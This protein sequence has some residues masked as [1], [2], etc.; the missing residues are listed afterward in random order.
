[1]RESNQ[2]FFVNDQKSLTSSSTYDLNQG[3]LSID[4]GIKPLPGCMKTKREDFSIC[5]DNIGHRIVACGGIEPFAHKMVNTIEVYDLK[6]RR[7][8]IEGTLH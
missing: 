5:Y 6:E 1:M 3:I 4:N 2:F 7:W 8:I